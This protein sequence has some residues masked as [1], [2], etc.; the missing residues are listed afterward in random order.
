MLLRWANSQFNNKISNK[1]ASADCIA[2]MIDE[3]KPFV[4]VC[5]YDKIEPEEANKKAPENSYF[6]FVIL[7]LILSL[8][9][10]GCI[11]FALPILREKL[12]CLLLWRGW[13]KFK[14]FRW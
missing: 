5:Y 10:L 6:Q 8:I 7:S 9:S 12:A 1:K 13:M 14:F 11:V 3:I 4:F 2:A